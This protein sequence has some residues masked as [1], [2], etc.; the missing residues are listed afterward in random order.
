[1][2]IG[3]KGAKIKRLFCLL[4]M[5]LLVNMAITQDTKA[6][7]M[8]DLVIVSGTPSGIMCA[9]AAAREGKRSV[10]LERTK[11]IGGLP[12]NGLGATDIITRS[13]TGGLFLEFVTRINKHYESVYGSNS[14]QVRD[15]KGGYHFEPSVAEKIMHQMLEEQPL[16]TVKINRQFDAYP[17][18]AQMERNQIKAITVLNRENNTSE[19]YNGKVFIDATYEG[20]LIAAA[21]VPFSLGREGKTEYNEPYAGIVYK[22]WEKDGQEAGSSNLGDNAIQAYNYRLCLTTDNQKKVPIPRPANYNREEYASIVDDV[23]SG[24]HSGVE[25][26]LQSVTEK[27][28][29]QQRLLKGLPPEGKNIPQG[30]QRLVNKVVLPNNKTDANNQHRSLV[31]TDLPEENWAWPT[32]DWQWRDKFAERLKDYTLGLLYF[33][34]NDPALPAWFRDS[35]ALW[36]LAA[37]EYTDNGNFPRQ[38]YVREGRRMKGVYVY[39]AGDAL[40]VQKGSRPPLHKTSITGGHYGIDSHATRKREKGQNT[41]EGFLSYSAAPYTVP[42]EVIVPPNVDNLLAPVPVSATHL[43]L[44]T[45]RMEPCWMALGQAAGVAAAVAIDHKKTVQDI[46][47]QVLQDR[48]IDQRAVL[49]CFKDAGPSNPDFKALQYLGLR[50][51]VTDWN[52]RLKDVATTAAIKNWEEKSG[53]ELADWANG[54]TR[55]E[56]LT[57]IYQK[58]RKN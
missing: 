50:G 22:L 53:L 25:W 21:G 28:R 29:N 37:D 13:A 46:D 5:Q 7:S 39:K 20:D 31:S 49:I 48:L 33:G 15:A 18:Y 42:Y 51:F 24:L 30:M 44:A 58:L 43:G 35:C 38:V 19:T 36:G 54:K 27:E 52:A 17:E 16:V 2:C 26:E 9:I 3:F 40:P 32:S 8:Y 11:H 23:R 4:A 10:I 57:H 34:Q 41:L 47:R 55:G 45:L 6:V 1:M 14:P 12:A 56:V